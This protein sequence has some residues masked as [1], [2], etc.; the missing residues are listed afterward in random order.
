MGFGNKIRRLREEK[1][2]TQAELAEKIGVSLR[3]VSSYEN[4]D[5]RP[6]HRKTYHILSD[7]FKVDVNYLLTDEEYFVL[8]TG[9]V[10]GPRGARDAQEIVN[11]MLGLF[12]GG[13]VSLEDKKAILDAIQEAYYMAKQE[14]KKYTPKKYR[15][16]EES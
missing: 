8:S 1:G 12:A 7:L 10:Y 14:N 3:T 9:E 15:K 16:N 6:R 2:W 5:Q 4:A 13:E 11:G